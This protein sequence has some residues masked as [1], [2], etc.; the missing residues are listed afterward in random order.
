MFDAI[1][2]GSGMS[3][4][5]V[6]KELCERGLKTLLLERGRHVEHGTDYT[7]WMEPWERP[8]LDGIPE[9]EA[10]RDYPIQSN[11]YAMTSATKQFWV[12]DSD[13]PYSTPEDRPFRWYRGFHLGGRSVT[14]HR[15]SYRLSQMDFEAN[16]REGIG[17]EWP[18]GYDDL[19]PWY[20]HIENF[21][22]VA[23]ARD[24]ID[25]LP[26]G[27]FL[28]PFGMTDF[29]RD[30][31]L[32]M[33]AAFPGRNFIHART[34]HLSEP[35]GHHEELG[36]GRCQARDICQSGCSYGAYYSSLSGALP[37][38]ER[39]GNLTIVTDAIVDSIQYDPQAGLVSGVR[40]IDAKT[41]GAR[42]YE[43]RIVFC[44]AST[45]PTAAILLASRS[46]AFPEGLANRSG[47]VG[48]NLM[49]HPSTFV[50]GQFEGGPNTYYRGRRPTA[51]YTPRYR[52]VTEPADFSRGFGIQWWGTR[53]PI[54]DNGLAQSGIGKGLME[55]A[56]TP[57]AWRM[58][59]IAFGEMLP[60]PKNRVTLHPTKKDKWGIALPHIDC[61]YGSNEQQMM[62]TAIADCREMIESAGGRVM[63]E[64]DPLAIPGEGIHEMGTACMGKDPSKSVLNGFNQAH[65]VPN[66]FISDGSAMASSACQ[67]PSL[68]YMA[69]SARAADAAAGMLKANLI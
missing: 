67:N 22:G 50:S 21:I 53:T 26:D 23:G 62:S 38:A 51:C 33:K 58:V 36:R 17:S 52:N 19:A 1:V 2:I 11:C 16:A 69:M 30:F 6:A 63:I 7:D 34:A 42:S 24:G 41:K 5:I 29:E 55:K 4:G 28:P 60:N 3:G 39:T 43:A 12:K 18:I 37:A 9:E 14:W 31:A 20:D 15:Q 46:E 25:N 61:S 65:D 27:D 57:G 32:K 59:M 54:L 66:L 13:H 44:N 68:T 8:H 47:M 40:V 48:R 56:R 45:I 49:D 35:R 10:A 64:S